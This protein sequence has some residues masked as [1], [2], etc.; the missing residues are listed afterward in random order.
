MSPSLFMKEDTIDIDVAEECRRCSSAKSYPFILAAD[1][2]EDKLIP[3]SFGGVV[4]YDALPLHIAGL[5]VARCATFL[6]RLR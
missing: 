6:R 5:F 4:L 1:A 3:L 2:D